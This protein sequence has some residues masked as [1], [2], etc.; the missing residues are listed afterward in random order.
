MSFLLYCQTKAKSS[1]C[2][3]A[4]DWPA[5]RGQKVKVRRLA[6]HS[7]KSSLR[8]N[9]R[10]LV[11]CER[12][13]SPMLPHEFPHPPRTQRLIAK[14]HHGIPFEGGG[15]TH[16]PKGAFHTNTTKG[17][18]HV[19]GKGPPGK[20]CPDEPP[21]GVRHK[22]PEIRFTRHSATW[23]GPSD[24]SAGEAYHSKKMQAKHMHRPSS[25]DGHWRHKMKKTTTGVKATHGSVNYDFLKPGKDYDDR[26]DAVRYAGSQEVWPFESKKKSLAYNSGAGDYDL[27]T[28]QV[29]T[30]RG[31]GSNDPLAVLP[32]PPRRP[33]PPAPGSPRQSPR[34]SNHGYDIINNNMYPE[35]KHI[36]K[37][38]KD[39]MNLTSELKNTLLRS[40]KTSVAGSSV[41]VVAAPETH[42]VKKLKPKAIRDTEGHSYNIL[43]METHHPEKLKRFDLQETRSFRRLANGQELKRKMRQRGRAN[44]EALQQRR[45]NTIAKTRHIAQRTTGSRGYNLVT[46]E[47][48][49]DLPPSDPR[50][51]PKF[52]GQKPRSWWSKL[53]G[54]DHD[55]ARLKDNPYKGLRNTA[56]RA[57]HTLL[58][59]D[60]SNHMRQTGDVL[61]K[62]PSR[63]TRAQD[64]VHNDLLGHHFGK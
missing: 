4:R 17:F 27:I 16:N 61:G 15:S 7:K 49:R 19:R 38:R 3:T 42:H 34:I 24:H 55:N 2:E 13:G 41:K 57:E 35:Y 52:I 40:R 63:V 20:L 56:G 60:I 43:T 39:S 31:D 11:T 47:R 6:V 48:S 8:R 53:S 37:M 51:D 25:K 50:R 30:R 21:R 23:G 62:L 18:K 64:I 59:R 45:A 29:D 46:G 14:V 28:H 33:K 54:S 5:I 58:P 9:C 26:N 44:A 10:A 1:I 22:T 36:E 12:D 32:S